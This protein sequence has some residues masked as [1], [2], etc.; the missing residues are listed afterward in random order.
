MRHPCCVVKL[1]LPVGGFALA[2]FIMATNTCNSSAFSPATTIVKMKGSASQFFSSRQQ[3]HAAVAVA[4]VAYAD[5]GEDGKKYTRKE[6]TR[7]SS[8]QHHYHRLYLFSLPAWNM[9]DTT[10]STTHH[11]ALL[12]KRLWEWKDDVL[13]DGRDFFVPRPNTLKK[14]NQLLT[15]QITHATECV[16]LSNCARFDVI[17]VVQVQVQQHEEE[18]ALFQRVRHQVAQALIQ[19]YTHYN[20]ARQEQ[21]AKTKA[22]TNS[23][24]PWTVLFFQGSAIGI[25][26]G[27]N[28]KRLCLD[29]PT[30]PSDDKHDEDGATCTLVGSSDNNN[31]SM[32]I[33]QNVKTLTDNLQSLRGPESIAHYLC[34]VATGLQPQGRRPD[35]QV[36]FRPYSSRDAHVMLQLK[37]TAEIAATQQPRIKALLDTALQSGKAARDPAMVP[38]ILALKKYSDSSSRYSLGNAPSELTEEAAKV[39]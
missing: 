10:T 35:R 2:F 16:V 12:V 21:K 26:G 6:H 36:V 4:V 20:K 22:K 24:S 17:V 39:S 18:E 31:N 37:R 28:P 1:L 27:D 14:L 19:Q 29:P 33:D 8:R 5:A 25:G 7:S 34:R 23:F 9:L 11:S 15:R 30:L 32:L 38:A 13:G 3:Q